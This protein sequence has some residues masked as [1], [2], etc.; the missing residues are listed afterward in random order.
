MQHTRAATATALLSLVVAVACVAPAATSSPVVTPTPS[1]VPSD[2]SAAAATP[3]SPPP[4]APPTAGDEP[5]AAELRAAGGPAL[6]GQLGT[7]T[8]RDGGSDAPW[9][10]GT[11][12]AVA[13]GSEL[14][15]GLAPDLPVDSWRARY[16]PAGADGPAR[17]ESLG[18][19][20][21]SIVLAPPPA[22]R[23]TLEVHVT[24]GASL[25]DAHY[26]WQL[27]IE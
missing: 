24:F 3:G 21:G 7:Y 17:A 26:F 19:G 6:P 2:E 20:G 5:P 15:I 9:L 14:V 8:W 12:V 13:A 10:P 27:D 22:G 11:P 16:A 18:E 25:G 4:T 23:W 1:A